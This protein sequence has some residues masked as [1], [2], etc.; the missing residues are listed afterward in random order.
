M[1]ELTLCYFYDFIQLGGVMYYCVFL[2]FMM[3]ME[4]GVE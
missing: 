1:L 3:L 4:P 2:A